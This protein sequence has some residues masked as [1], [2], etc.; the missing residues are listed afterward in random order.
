MYSIIIKSFLFFYLYNLV[1]CC[2]NSCK[3][4]AGSKGEL[5]NTGGE[6]KKIKKG[7]KPDKN[8]TETEFK[9]EPENI[10]LHIKMKSKYED[11]IKKYNP[12]VDVDGFIWEIMYN[13]AVGNKKVIDGKFASLEEVISSIFNFVSNVVS[14]KDLETEVNN[15]SY[16]ICQG[17]GIEKEDLMLNDYEIR[18]IFKK[19]KK[20]E[21]D[22]DL[23]EI[24]KYFEKRL[25]K[26][27]FVEVVIKDV[28]FPKFDITKEFVI[29]TFLDKD[30]AFSEEDIINFINDH[31]KV[32]QPDSQLNTKE[33]NSE[34]LE[35]DEKADEVYEE[36][37]RDYGIS[38][39]MDEDEVKAKIKK[40]GY[41]GDKVREWVE[42][43][44]LNHPS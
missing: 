37:D 16:V 26:K 4:N 36:I 30:E 44:L 13:Y 40:L 38:S 43:V 1:L 18:E 28:D 22:F 32:H 34:T 24:K 9:D 6:Y 39:F 7:F 2:N 5:D 27:N 10:N 17:M 19:N 29:K 21:N 14:E 3:T 8:I 31:K 12:D 15:S 25:E 20:P 11:L 33:N 41:D 35:K 23:V 42:E